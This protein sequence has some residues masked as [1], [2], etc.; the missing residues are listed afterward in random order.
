MSS[1]CTVH[2]SYTRERQRYSDNIST[3]LTNVYPLFGNGQSESSIKY[4]YIFA[5]EDVSRCDDSEAKR[6]CE[7]KCRV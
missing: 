1:Y 4:G 6:E 3:E 2:A 5:I 7:R